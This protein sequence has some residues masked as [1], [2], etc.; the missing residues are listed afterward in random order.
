MMPKAR[1]AGVAPGSHPSSYRDRIGSARLWFGLFGAAGAWSVQTLISYPLASHSCYPGIF[2]LRTPI[3]PG[4]WT[5]LLLVGLACL[6][7][8]LSG[9]GAAWTA[10]K[11]TRGEVGEDHHHLFATGEGRSRFMALSGVIVSATM[12][13][14]ILLQ[15]ATLFLVAPCG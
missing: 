11:K 6:V 5:V 14:A 8:G 10:W 1:L 2:P 9:L 15:T 3:L 13:L 7:V 4:L 12:L